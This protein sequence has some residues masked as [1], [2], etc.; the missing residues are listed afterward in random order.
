M[1][2]PGR[3]TPTRREALKTI[4]AATAAPIVAATPRAAL[5]QDRPVTK[6]L[7]FTT[8]ADLAKAEQEGEFLFYS[9]DS[10]PAIAG[11]LEAFGKDFPKIKGKYVRA[12][13]GALFSR[14]I[15]ERSA[16]RFTADVIQ[17][18]EESTAVDFQKRG[19]YQRYIS[20][21]A[22]FYAPEHLSKPAGD[23]F[24]TSVTFAGIAYN[25]TKVKPEDAPKG[26]KDVLKPVFANGVNCKQSSSG[27]QFVQWFELR[28]LYGDEFWKEFSKLKPRGFDSRAQQFDRLAK[29]DDK[30]CMLAEYAGYLLQKEKGAPIEFVAPADGLPAAPLLC[31]IA[32]KAPHPEASRLFVDW[33][34]SLRGQNHQQTNPYLYYGSVR[35]DAPAMPGGRRLADYKLLPAQD[36]DAYAA[37]RPQ[38]N[39]EW[40]AM[41]GL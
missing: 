18:S 1:R 38:F 13:N 17:Y 31:G 3:S 34:M 32:D 40:N 4:L 22:E 6:V 20:P 10:E 39:K 29:G 25:S 26:W 23:Y 11:I 36:L 28:K 8:G 2:K 37:A 21:Q 27:M 41:L 35:K 30:L 12:Q 7:D 5:A 19:G 14:T 16:G 9:H 15:A 24:W 33:Q